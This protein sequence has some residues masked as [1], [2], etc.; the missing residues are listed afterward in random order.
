MINSN[1][2][3]MLKLYRRFFGFL[4]PDGKCQDLLFSWHSH[5][6]TSLSEMIRSFEKCTLGIIGAVRARHNDEE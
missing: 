1:V 3:V 5:P 4:A 6:K 2:A